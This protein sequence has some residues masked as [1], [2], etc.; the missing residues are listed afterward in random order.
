MV[1]SKTSDAPPSSKGAGGINKKKDPPFA[2]QKGDSLCLKIYVQP[3]ASKSSISG[4]HDGYLK[5]RISSPP[6]EG[7]ANEALVEFLSDAFDVKKSR[8]E[9]LE[10]LKS[11]KKLLRISGVTMKDVEKLTAEKS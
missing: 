3:G 10:G 2:I 5:I 1:A 9:I 6:V 8:I 11:R 7:K 4:E